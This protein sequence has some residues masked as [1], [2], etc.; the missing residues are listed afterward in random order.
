MT[1]R[2]N[3]TPHPID[4][5]AAAKLLELLSSDDAFR[6]AFQKD[7]AT[8]L[9]SIGVSLEGNAEVCCM[10]V[11]TLAS[12]EEILAAMELL[13]KYLVSEAVFQNPH[14]FE[15]NQVGNFLKSGG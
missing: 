15:A 2:E 9:T 8:A 12:K 7:A 11:Q 4:P 13:L 6:A 5:A 14:C 3:S 10:Q 1:N